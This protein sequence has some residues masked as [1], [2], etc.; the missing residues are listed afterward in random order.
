MT[1]QQ[2]QADPMDPEDEVIES[3]SLRLYALFVGYSVEAFF[4]QLTK[5]TRSQDA[6][7]RTASAT[8]SMSEKMA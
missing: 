6:P 1:P 3:L 5:Y 7:L 2:L 8:I 4:S